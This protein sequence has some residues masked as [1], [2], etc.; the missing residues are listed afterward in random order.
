MT[1]K[2]SKCGEVKDVGEFYIQK[3]KK[4]RLDSYCKKCNHNIYRDNH[5][6]DITIKFKKYWQEWGVKGCIGCGEYKLLDLFYSTKISRCKECYKKVCD[7]YKHRNGEKVRE[8]ANISNRKWYLRNRDNRREEGRRYA[9]KLSMELNDPYIKQQIKMSLGLCDNDISQEMIQ[10]KRSK[11]IKYRV[12]KL[13]ND[14]QKNKST[15]AE[16]SKQF[17]HLTQLE[18]KEYA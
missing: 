11:I 13:Y 15:L 6:I 8:R 7:V 9:K 4:N 14:V 18:E 10:D 12:I 5:K 1:K 2:C 16:A 17:N 3:T